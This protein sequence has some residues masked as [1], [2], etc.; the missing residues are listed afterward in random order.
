MNIIYLFFILFLIYLENYNILANDE[1]INVKIN[2]D[3]L[4]KR[5]YNYLK[6]KKPEER[7]Y[8]K[9]LVCF[10]KIVNFKE[11][12]RRVCQHQHIKIYLKK[13]FNNKQEIK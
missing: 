11:H 9:N 10:K 7:F 4:E 13:F 6:N 12:P 3:W 5:E 1:N 8:F 2:S